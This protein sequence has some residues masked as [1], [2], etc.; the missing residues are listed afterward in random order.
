MGVVLAFPKTAKADNWLSAQEWAQLRQLLAQTPFEMHYE[1]F[2]LDNGPFHIYIYVCGWIAPSF[3]VEK[4]AGEW[5]IIDLRKSDKT[6]ICT[7]GEPEEI[8]RY[9]VQ[10]R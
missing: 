3:E 10:Q 9:L 7:S 5:S 4:H 1:Q 8:V 6:T 2:P